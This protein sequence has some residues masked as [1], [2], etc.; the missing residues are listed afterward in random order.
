[1]DDNLRST[2]IQ[3]QENVVTRLSLKDYTE[4]KGL[5]CP[6]C[7]F[8]APSELSVELD[9]AHNSYRPVFKHRIPRT[10]EVFVCTAVDVRAARGC[11]QKAMKSPQHKLEE[12]V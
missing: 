10:C 9:P 3:V 2:D 11:V 5:L 4:L 1:M 7:A 12:E 6:W 8:G